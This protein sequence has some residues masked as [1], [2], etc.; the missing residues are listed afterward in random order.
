[1]QSLTDILREL[2]T[3]LMDPRIRRSSEAADMIADDFME[4]GA[5]AK[6]TTRRMR[7]P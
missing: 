4:F 5:V 1:M 6:C 2:E 3:R 7:L